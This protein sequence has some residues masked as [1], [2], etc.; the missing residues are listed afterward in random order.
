MV[1]KLT[2][3]QNFPEN[4]IENSIEGEFIKAALEHEVYKDD[5]SFYLMDDERAYLTRSRS[6]WEE[7]AKRCKASDSTILQD[8]GEALSEVLAEE[9]GGEIEVHL[10][11]VG[12]DYPELFQSLCRKYPDEIPYVEVMWAYTDRKPV[13]GEHGGG[14]YFITK[15]A[16]EITRTSDWLSEKR[17]H[18][19]ANNEQA[20]A[21]KL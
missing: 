20:A 6:D 16:I 3:D 11:A 18:Y 9:E 10:P 17:R 7:V 4:I 1:L 19:K 21:P 2:V 8:A 14:A 12:L 13:H 15:D 5:Y